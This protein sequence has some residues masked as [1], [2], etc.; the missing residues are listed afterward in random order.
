MGRTW[1]DRKKRE[2]GRGR[3]G[4]YATSHKKCQRPL[5]KGRRI[6]EGEKKTV[7]RSQSQASGKGGSGVPQLVSQTECG[8]VQGGGEKG[9][10]KEAKQKKCVLQHQWRLIFSKD[11][12]VDRV[13]SRPV[14]TIKGG[15]S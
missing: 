3:G 4:R 14:L 2:K 5:R 9:A 1:V 10:W 11:K 6:S 15:S 8:A 12:G 7:Q 13:N